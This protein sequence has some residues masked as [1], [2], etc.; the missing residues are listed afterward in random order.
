[1]IRIVPAAGRIAHVLG[2]RPTFDPALPGQRENGIRYERLCGRT[3]NL[4]DQVWEPPARFV[5]TAVLPDARIEE[6]PGQAH[7]GIYS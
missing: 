3:W 6:L 4:C 7:E 2:R 1:M 5:K